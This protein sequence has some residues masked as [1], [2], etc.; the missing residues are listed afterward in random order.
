MSSSPYSLSE[1][2]LKAH[3]YLSQ[4]YRDALPTMMETASRKAPTNLA[5]YEFSPMASHPIINPA[6]IKRRTAFSDFQKKAGI[7]N[8]PARR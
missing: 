3:L 6:G 5:T 1:N 7:R 4:K 8:A 2:P